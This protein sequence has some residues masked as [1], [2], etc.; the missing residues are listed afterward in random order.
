MKPKAE[1][2]LFHG[3][4]IIVES[5]WVLALA[6]FVC[7]A[8]SRRPFPVFSG[9]IVFLAAAAVTRGS[10]EKGWRR[11]SLLAVHLAGMLG[12]LGMMCLAEEV[13][14]EQLFGLVKGGS[15]A[16]PRKVWIDWIAVLLTGFWTVILWL[17]GTALSRRPGTYERVCGQ[18]DRGVVAFGLLFLVVNLAR[19]RGGL[20]LAWGPAMPLFALFFCASVL[21]MGMAT[22]EAHGTTGDQVRFQGVWVLSAFSFL[23]VGTGIGIILFLMPFLNQ[24]AHLAFNTLKETTSPLGPILIRCLRFVFAH[25]RT[26]PEQGPSRSGGGDVAVRHDDPEAEVTILEEVLG[27]GLT[28]LLAAVLVVVLATVGILGLKALLAR[29]GS[30]RSDVSRGFSIGA[31]FMAW[32]GVFRTLSLGRWVRV[33]R[34]PG[35]VRLYGRLAKWGKRSGLPQRA[36]E[37]PCEYGCRLS[38][39]FLPLSRDIEQIVD[40]VNREVYG[41]VSLDPNDRLEGRRAWRCLRSPCHWPVRVRVWLTGNDAGTK[42]GWK[43]P[44]YA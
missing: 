31:W 17:K 43:V 24:G 26:P 15:G 44:G 25:R 29:S 33:L 1:Q 13:C 5:S 40:L 6:G 18:F 28:G 36:N 30:R 39:A 4:R 2:G 23:I 20:D 12:S 32:L 19:I 35:P 14:R 16:S 7:Y 38:H 10:Q 42:A 9:I 41:D 22:P 8:V 34:D 11:V 3:T 27:W 37:T 21:A